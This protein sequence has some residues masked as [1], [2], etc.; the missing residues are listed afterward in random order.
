MSGWSIWEVR[1]SDGQSQSKN[2][3]SFHR[4][5]E[6][7]G[8]EPDRSRCHAAHGCHGH[9]SHFK[10]KGFNAFWEKVAG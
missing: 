6:P 2:I 5:I 4:G 3:G 1:S 7:N 9:A 8:I 10:V